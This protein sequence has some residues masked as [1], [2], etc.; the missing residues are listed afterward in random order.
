MPLND[1]GTAPE[2]KSL[3]ASFSAEKDAVFSLEKAPDSPVSTH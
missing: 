2:N 3:S 1:P